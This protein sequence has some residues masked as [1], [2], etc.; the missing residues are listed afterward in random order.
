VTP[1]LLFAADAADRVVSQA[2]TPEAVHA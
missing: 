2:S 1:D